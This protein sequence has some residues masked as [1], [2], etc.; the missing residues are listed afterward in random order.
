MDKR[1]T[2]LDLQHESAGRSKHER[3]RDHL[4]G[5]MLA[6]RLKPGQIIPSQRYFVEALG[7]APMT[8]RQAMASLENEGLI[9]RVQGKGTFVDTDA[10]RKLKRGLD[11]LALIVPETREGFYPSLLHGFEDAAS[12]IHHQTIICNTNESVER[13]GDIILQLLDKK[14]G[15]VA[16]NPMG[17]PLTPAYQVRQLQE[18]G[19]PVVFCHRGV[20]GVTAPLLSIPFYDVG[21]RAGNALAEQ[22]HRHVACFTGPPSCLTSR[23]YE[24]GLREALQ[25]A[26]SDAVIETIH[27]EAGPIKTTE[28]SCWQAI[29]R[30]FGKPDAPTAIF[31][32]FDSTAE[33][34][35]L[36]L[37]RLGLR[38]PEDVSLVGVGGTWREDAFTRRLT[39]V[40]IDEIATGK[41]AVGLLDEMRRGN[42]PIDDNEEFVLPL[43]LSDGETLG[44]PNHG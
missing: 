20:D 2:A 25:A 32:S 29:E 9:R 4:V 23:D 18:H 11:I 37:P 16:L 6:G 34:I 41:K 10:R 42:R 28:D 35:Y 7:V 21:R 13:Q 40:V 33:V 30:L 15:G 24:A 12:A 43:G 31:T 36:L 8:V 19:I 22:G 38:A 27:I 5:E 44:K 26:N 39:S 1:L 14:V 17:S 3:L